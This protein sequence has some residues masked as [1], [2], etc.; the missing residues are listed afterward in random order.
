AAGCLAHLRPPAVVGPR[1]RRLELGIDAFEPHVELGPIDHHHVDT[2]DLDRLRHPVAGEP[3]GDD[4]L[5]V[6]RDHVR[7]R[8]VDRLLEL[9][10]DGGRVLAPAAV[11]RDRVVMVETGRAA[12]AHPIHESLVEEPGPE[13]GGIDH[14][15]I[16]V[17][18]LQA[19]AHVASTADATKR[20]PGWL[21]GARKPSSR[22][23]RP[24]GTRSSPSRP[25]SPPSRA[26]P[27]PR[28]GRSPTPPASSLEACTTTSTRRS[29]WWTTSSEA[30]STTSSPDTAPLPAGTIPWASCARS[31]APVSRPSTPT[32]RRWPS[33]ST[34]T[35]SSSSTHGLPSCATQQKRPSG[36]GSRC[37][38]GGWR[39]GS[40]VLMSRPAWCT[41]SC[42]TPS[43]S[44]CGGTAPTGA[45]GRTRS[46]TSTSRRWSRGSR[47]ARRA[48]PRCPRQA[49]QSLRLAFPRS[50]LRSP[51]ASGATWSRERA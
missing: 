2:L 43:G 46:P 47:R 44:A 17:E 42:A 40:S 10:V 30:S 20:A 38:S 13:V 15:S 39:R 33:C 28:F 48:M 21:R 23:S 19:V 22:S 24:G 1:H 36:S 25:A 51:C 50:R 35:T 49:G 12:T 26:S 3:L 37:S 45:T 31:C 16:G 27:P 18:D 6:L 14:M 32:A 4:L 9:A 41:A 8:P 5:A 29:R 11:D 7:G 34:S